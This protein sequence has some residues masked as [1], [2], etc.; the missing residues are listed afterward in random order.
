MVLT[1]FFFFFWRS[2]AYCRDVLLLYPKDTWKSPYSGDVSCG[3]QLNST[4]AKTFLYNR[5]IVKILRKQQNKETIKVVEAFVVRSRSH[6]KRH[7]ILTV[8]T[9]VWR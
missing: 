7:N 5:T 8:R 1:C 2:G 3:R 6:I 9:F 4:A